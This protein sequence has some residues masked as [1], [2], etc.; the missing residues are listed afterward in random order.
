MEQSRVMVC[1][2]TNRPFDLDEAMHRRI[3]ASFEFRSP[4]HIDRAKLWQGH[5]EGK[6]PVC[7]E[8]DWE[9]ISLK[10]ELTGGFIK[11]AVLSALMAAVARDTEAPLITE[12][13]LVEGCQLQMRGSLQMKSFQNRVVPKQG[14][15][16]LVLGEELKAK[17]QEIVDFEKARAV[18]FGQWGFAE[19]MQRKQGVSALFF[20]SVGCGK[21]MAAA[22]IGFEVGKP[23]K[24]VSCSQLLGEDYAKNIKATFNDAR[25]MGAVLVLEEAEVILDP[26]DKLRP[27]AKAMLV[28]QVGN[29]PG[30]VILIAS[31]GGEIRSDRIIYENKPLMRHLKFILH[32]EP[33]KEEIRRRLWEAA[34]P[35]RAP[36]QKEPIDFMKLAKRFAFGSGGIA[37]AVV[38]AAAT[39]ALR[40]SEKRFI[41]TK[42]LLAAAEVEKAKDRTALDTM[43]EMSYI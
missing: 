17:L 41:T 19:D 22:A 13:D 25:L 27:E 7:P 38:R 12:A 29:F 39:A 26:S 21:N 9:S 16:E 28:Q 14:L 3:T 37:N 30:I 40:P 33:P 20:G 2:A 8:V 1:L 18:L 34:I 35:I 6:V 5:V 36:V 43:A 23:L 42:D 31:Y 4:D 10:Y 32:F 15:D 11:N 24:L